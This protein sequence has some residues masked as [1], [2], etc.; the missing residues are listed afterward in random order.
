MDRVP[1]RDRR[2][3]MKTDRDASKERRRTIRPL[4]G[5]L[6]RWIGLLIAGFLFSSGL[7]GAVISW[8]HELDELLNPHLLA[9]RASGPALSSFE[10]ARA[11]ETR[12]PRMVVT[13]VPLAVAPGHS[14][15]FGVE[16]RVDPDTEHPFEASFNQ[17]FVDPA[18]GAEL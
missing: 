1:R 4:F 18:D 10:L 12:H 7:T 3:L 16:P 5:R 9:A 15:A 14:M 8:D 17:V 2:N 13:Y 11:I 6:H